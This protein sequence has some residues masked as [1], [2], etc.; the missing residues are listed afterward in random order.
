M[1][2][3][4]I[5]EAEGAAVEAAVAEIRVGRMVVVTDDAGRENEGDLVMAARFATPVA[6]NFMAR[7]ARGLI[8][9]P[10]TGRRLAELGLPQITSENTDR[11]GTAFAIPVDHVET[12]TGIS[13]SDRAL[14]IRALSDPASTGK[15]FRRPG[16]VFPLAARDGGLAERRGHTE[17]AVE[18]VARA[19]G[20]DGGSAGVICEIMNEDGSMA[21][22]KE[23]EEFAH[24]HGLVSITVDVLARRALSRGGTIRRSAE[25][26]LPTRYGTFRLYG[27]SDPATRSEHV[28]LVMGDAASGEPVLAR[29]HSECLTGDALG[30]RRCDCGEQYEEAMRR[31]GEAGR[32]VLVYL[33]QEGRGIGLVNKLRAYALQDAGADTVE[34]NVA[35]GFRP[36]ER[37][38]SAGVEI[39]R[40]LGVKRVLLMTN[41]PEKTRALTDGGIEIA[42]RIPIVI[43]PNEWNT[44][45]LRTKNE[46][47]GHIE[48]V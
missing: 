31:I 14:T 44:G 25:T 29:V 36:D 6:V 11:H 46:K 3:E 20:P 34:A 12:G 48:I 5:T 26:V 21:R 24:L 45:Y 19:L 38:Y 47:M 18:L 42:A 43:P 30:S 4:T 23:L 10:M 15:S 35:L 22:G 9:V 2:N 39:L 40:D 17:A 37:D 28:A 1:N 33:R 16:H 13:A 32:G 27:Y 8:C 41:N 7:H